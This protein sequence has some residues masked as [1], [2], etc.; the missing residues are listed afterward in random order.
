MAEHGM[1][2]KAHE[3]TYSG[4]LSLIKFGAIATAVVVAIVVLLIAS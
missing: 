2:M 3:R 1:E 4:F